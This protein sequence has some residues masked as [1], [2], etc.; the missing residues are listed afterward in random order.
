MHKQD[1]ATF[2]EKEVPTAQPGDELVSKFVGVPYKDGEGVE[3]ALDIQ[4][5]APDSAH[6]P[7]TPQ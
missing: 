7:S 5:A 3:A 1:L 4:A 6:P 2:F